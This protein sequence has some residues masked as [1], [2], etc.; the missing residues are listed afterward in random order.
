MILPVVDEEVKVIPVIPTA[1]NSPAAPTPSPLGDAEEVKG[2][3][4]LICPD[5]VPTVV[6]VIVVRIATCFPT[7]T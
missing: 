5:A 7:L 2:N 3:V 1:E 4:K 6:I